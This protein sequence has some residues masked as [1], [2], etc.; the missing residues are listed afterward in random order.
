MILIYYSFTV[1]KCKDRWNSADIQ[2]QAKKKTP[3][4]TSKKILFK[5][6]SYNGRWMD[7]PQVLI[8]EY[9]CNNNQKN[10]QSS[11]SFVRINI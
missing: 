1:C 7:L 8:N 9:L 6:K 3:A 4:K 5:A 2:N 11:N 10:N